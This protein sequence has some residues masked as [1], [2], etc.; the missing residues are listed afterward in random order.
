LRSRILTQDVLRTRHIQCQVGCFMCHLG[1]EKTAM[2]LVFKC[3]WARQVWTGIKDRLGYRALIL[4]ESV[5]QTWDRS[6]ALAGRPSIW[7]KIGPLV[8]MCTAWWIWRS[9]NE[10]VFRG[11]E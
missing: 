11:T 2:H 8:L 6:L 10:R 3:P 4:R 7:K 9:R 5:Q 1:Q